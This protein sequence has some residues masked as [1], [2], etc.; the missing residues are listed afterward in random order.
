LNRY[1]KVKEEPYMTFD[2][3]EDITEEQ[4]LWTDVA[5]K[6][7]SKSK[8]DVQDMINKMNNY[9]KTVVK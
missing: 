1:R 4:E 7:Y 3:V 5:L 6:I 2:T 8:S 9:K